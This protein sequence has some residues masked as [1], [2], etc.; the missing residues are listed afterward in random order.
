MG[1]ARP[2]RYAAAERH[3]TTG[4]RMSGQ[5]VRDWATDFDVGDAR[6]EQ[7]PYPIWADLRRTAPVAHTDRRGGAHLPTR[8]ED[9]AAV[10]YDTGHFSSRDVGVLPSPPGASLLVAPPITSDPPMHTEARRILLPHFGPKAVERLTHKT[11]EIT[12]S[13]LDAL[14]GRDRADAAADYA[15]HIPVRV[16]AHMLGIPESDEAIFTGWAVR[17]LQEAA[18]DPEIGRAATREVLAYFGE[19]VAQRREERG[20]DLISALLDAELD[21]GPLTDK[22]ILGT[23]FL[24]LLA[25]IDTTWSSISSSLWHLA[26]HPEDRARLVADPS[27]IPTATEEFLRAYAP[28][29]MGR[30]AVTDTEIAGVPVR[31]GER[32]LL[33]FP[34]GNRDPEQFERPDEVVIDREHNRHFAFGI[35]V[36]RCLGSN[37]ARMELQVAISDWITRFP[38][39]TLEPGAEVRWGGQQIRGPREVPVL[40]HG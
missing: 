22:H 15:Q 9:I 33:A 38:D 26:T 20:E 12:A 19:Q 30:V 18:T 2:A 24:L 7:D 35:G 25:G 17:I 29:T 3:T 10:A 32:V 11:R 16:I 6:Y 36:H 27:L 14:D 31:A 5:P 28:V 8:Y 21:G 37:L 39:F 34:A 13:L 40:L 1:A 23:C 4:E